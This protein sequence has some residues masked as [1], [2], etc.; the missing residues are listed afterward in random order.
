MNFPVIGL[1]IIFSALLE[2]AIFLPGQYWSSFVALSVFLFFVY[3]R[4][5]GNTSHRGS[6]IFF[7]GIFSWGLLFFMD[8]V[9]EQHLFVLLSSILFGCMLWGYQRWRKGILLGAT[10][11]VLSAV[12]LASVFLF[13]SVLVGLLINYNVPI[14]VF[15][16]VLGF[17]VYM[18]TRQYLEGLV[19][20]SQTRVAAYSISVGIFFLELGTIIRFWPFGYLTTGVILLILYYVLWDVLGSYVEGTLTRPKVWGDIVVLVGLSFLVL[21]TTPWTIV[22]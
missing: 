16:G 6:L 9:M 1:T 17:G 2:Y 13:F 7:F 15:A 14:G 11:S 22:L 10:K 20:E 18:L 4:A 8:D 5:V 3:T 12:T 21:L 19:E